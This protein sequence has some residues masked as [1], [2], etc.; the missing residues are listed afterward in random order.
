MTTTCAPRS[1]RAADAA[2]TFAC[3]LALAVLLLTAVLLDGPQ[4][5]WHCTSPTYAE[6]TCAGHHDRSAP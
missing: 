6:R 3:C 2:R 4:R 1:T 5:Q